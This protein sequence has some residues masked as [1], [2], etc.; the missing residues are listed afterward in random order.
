MKRHLEGKRS[1]SNFIKECI[2][3]CA[4]HKMM[5]LRENFGVSLREERGHIYQE[6]LGTNPEE[7]FMFECRVIFFFLEILLY[8]SIHFVQQGEEG[9]KT[10]A[11]LE[12]FFEA[13]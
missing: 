1:S 12:Q 11:T 6:I 10:E 13:V 7:E 9:M 8:R 5:R 2:W 4:R 3:Q